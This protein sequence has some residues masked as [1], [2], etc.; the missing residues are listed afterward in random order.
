[1]R[2]THIIVTDIERGDLVKQWASNV[3]CSTCNKEAIYRCEPCG[4]LEYCRACD[5]MAHMEDP[6]NHERLEIQDAYGEKFG[7]CEMHPKRRNEYYD[8][9]KNRAFCTDCAIDMA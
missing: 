3:R 6:Q 1:M 7:K 9:N 8:K 4:G 2:L 5:A